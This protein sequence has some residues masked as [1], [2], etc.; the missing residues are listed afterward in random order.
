MNTIPPYKQLENAYAKFAKTKYAISCSSGTSGLHLALLALGI[1]HGD[2]VIL[3]DFTMAACGFAVEYVGATAVF[4]DC[5]RDLNINTNQIEKRITPKT[6]AIMAVDIYGRKCDYEAIS[7]IAKKHNLFIIRDACEGQGIEAEA[8]ITVYSFYK[9]KIIHAEEGG[10]VCTN[11][12]IWDS[13]VRYLKSMSFGPKH[14]YYHEHI[15][16]NYRM[17]DSQA[18]LALESLKEVKSN[19]KKRKQIEAWYDS[20]IPEVYQMPQ[21]DVVWVYDILHP[22]KEE[23]LK[24]VVGSRHF[25]KPLSTMP[26]WKDVGSG[27]AKVF[28]EIGCY[29]PVNPKMT[30]KDVKNICKTIKE[31]L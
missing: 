5:G 3:P 11:N 26:M 27:T 7:K 21:R 20:M 24:K 13:C 17:P 1:G 22:R 2:E 12:P 19:L 14:D 16:Y 31:L 8:D 4:V 28:A 30:K 29:L 18:K 9:N 6:K 25:F 23:I 15:G 10:I